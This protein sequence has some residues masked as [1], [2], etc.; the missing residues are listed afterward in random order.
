MKISEL[1]IRR[2]IYVIVLFLVI[3]ILGFIG[4]KSLQ[5]ELMPKFTPPFECD[6]AY[7][8]HLPLGGKSLTRKLEEPY[9]P[10]RA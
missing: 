2:P 7:R 3:A 9:P 8:A 6:G 1:S 4:F 10:F 5:A